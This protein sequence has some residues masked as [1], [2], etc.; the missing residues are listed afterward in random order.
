[1]VRVYPFE[2]S[3][4]ASRPYKVNTSGCLVILQVVGTTYAVQALNNFSGL[5]IDDSQPARFMLVSA[6]NVACMR[7]QPA[8]YKQAMMSFIEPVPSITRKTSC[9]R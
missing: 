3:N 6:S 1:M 7:F 8:A 5:R 2:Y 9:E 4:R